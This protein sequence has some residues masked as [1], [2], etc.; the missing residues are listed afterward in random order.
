MVKRGFV[1]LDAECRNGLGHPKNDGAPVPVAQHTGWHSWRRWP[2]DRTGLSHGA[3]GS[4]TH[5]AGC[6]GLAEQSGWSSVRWLRERPLRWQN[7]RHRWHVRFAP[8]SQRCRHRI[9]TS[10]SFF[11]HTA[12]CSRNSNLRQRASRYD[13]CTGWHFKSTERSRSGGS[14]VACPR[15]RRL[16]KSS[17][18]RCTLY[19]RLDFSRR[20]SR[21]RLPRLRVTWRR[22]SV[23]GDSSN[24]SSDCGSIGNDCAARSACT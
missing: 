7:T 8:L 22:V 2:T 3:L 6:G 9:S 10:H 12:R 21:S 1:W 17:N 16:G 20:S 15:S 13:A 23:F 14:Y 18:D 24:E 11:A 19:Q 5:D 4:R